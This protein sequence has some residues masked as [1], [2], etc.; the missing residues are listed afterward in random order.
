[1][2]LGAFPVFLYLSCNLPVGM[3]LQDI[4]WFY[5]WATPKKTYFASVSE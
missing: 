5:S 1:M 4:I 3:V 2:D